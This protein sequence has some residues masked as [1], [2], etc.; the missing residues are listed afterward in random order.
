MTF[1]LMLWAPSLGRHAQRPAHAARRLGQG[2]H[3]PGAQVLRRG[4]DLLRHG[5]LRGAAARDQVGQRPRALHGLDHRPRPRRHA[6]L[7]RLHGRGHDLLA[8]AAPLEQAAAH[9]SALANLHFWIGLVGILLY[10]VR[11]VDERHHAG[12]DAQ[13]HDRQR[14]G[15]RV[16]QL[17]RHRER[18][19][20]DD[21]DARRW[22]AASTWP[23]GFSWPTT[24]CARSRG[25][26]P[27]NGT[28]EVFV[29]PPAAGRRGWASLGAMLQPA[30]AL[31]RPR[32][33]GLPAPG[34]SAATASASLGVVG[35][36]ASASSLAFLHFES[37]GRALGATG[38]TG[39]WSRRCRSRC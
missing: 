25:A 23:A 34:C 37:R 33:S 24:S 3:R 5:D 29:E 12:P 32:R 14:H 22:A 35:R 31:L 36:D 21:A 39:C 6:R 13:R 7:E 19:P 1:S 15:A 27:V 28:I 2:A 20:P 38:T 11:D 17:P 9:R 8:A 10:V 16:S 4:R 30:G 18:H 26:Q